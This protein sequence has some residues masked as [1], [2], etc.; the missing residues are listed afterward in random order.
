M[1]FL[2]SDSDVVRLIQRAPRRPDGMLAIDIPVASLA[3]NVA[4]R[5]LLTFSEESR[6]VNQCELSARLSPTQFGLLRYVYTHGRTG[7]EELQD[8]VWRSAKVS[9]GSIRTACS[10]VNAKLAEAD[11]RVELS[12]HHGRVSVE[13]ID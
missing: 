11:F 9:D 8:S 5:P 12:A 10:K 13:A 6:T 1:L 3:E 7:F 4:E 2:L